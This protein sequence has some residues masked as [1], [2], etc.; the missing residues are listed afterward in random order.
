M[1]EPCP[2]KGSATST[3]DVCEC[4]GVWCTVSHAEGAEGRPR[5]GGGEGG[6]EGADVR[7]CVDADV[8]R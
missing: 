1:C 8:D 7:T 4:C 2:W 5:E 6:E 3:G